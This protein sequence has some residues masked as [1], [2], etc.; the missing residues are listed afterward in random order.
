[1]IV[2]NIKIW[3]IEDEAIIAESLKYTLEDLGYDVVRISYTLKEAEDAI[4]E[5]EFDLLLLDINLGDF[6][7][8]SGFDLLEKMQSYN[9]Q[10][11][12]IFLTAYNDLDIIKKA[13]EYKP[14]AY[15][16][17]PIS[18]SNLF[19]ALQLAFHNYSL[20]DNQNVA[21]EY[22]IEEQPKYFFSKIGTKKHKVFWN[23][24][25]IL[26]SIKN[27]VS[28]RTA[29]D[30]EYLIRGSLINV[31]KSMLPISEKDNF[32]RINRKTYIRHSIIQ[33][34]EEPLVITSIGTFKITL[35]NA[36]IILTK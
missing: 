30:K 23:D 9:L 34:I 6:P 5:V 20:E 1:M 36:K 10:F 4:Q 8:K 27:Y 31:V 33:S 11:P 22:S 25:V 14:S 12:F 7:T 21:Y 35:E 29:I 32:V 24:V 19:A 13:L 28:V 26:E 15:L 2:D 17:K 16:V 3:I 18:V